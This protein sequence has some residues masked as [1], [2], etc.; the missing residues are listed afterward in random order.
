MQLVAFVEDH[1]RVE[2]LPLPTLKGLAEIVKVG[3][4]SVG[5]TVTTAD[6]AV[7]PPDPEH[8]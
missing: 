4:G 5:V 2:L 8:V 3:A 6:S 1:V 7:D